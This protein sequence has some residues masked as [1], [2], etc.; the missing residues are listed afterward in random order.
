[1]G[2]T[3]LVA[4][5]ILVLFQGGFFTI[6]V[7][8]CGLVCLA[9]SFVAALQRR[10]GGLKGVV[11]PILFF[12]VAAAYAVSSVANGASL[13]TLSET[14]FWASA[15]AVSLLASLQTGEERGWVLGGLAW[16][17]AVTSLLGLAV[18]A[19]V[20]PLAAGLDAERLQFTFQ[21]ANAAGVWYAVCTM[22]CLLEPSRRLCAVAA[23]PATA[24]LL[25]ESGGATVAFCMVGLCVG[26]GL[27]KAEKWDL[28]LKALVS[29]AIAVISFG[30]I[31]FA[32]DP[33]LLAASV[34]PIAASAIAYVLLLHAEL[35]DER[36]R[37]LSLVA[38]AVAVCAVVLVAVLRW[39]RIVQASGTFVE[40]FIQMKDG[41]SLWSEN[42]LLGVGPDNWKHLYRYVQTAQYNSSVI[43]S[44]CVQILLDAGIAAAIPMVVA[45]L[46]GARRLW[47]RRKAVGWSAAE[48]ACIALITLHSFVDFD[49]KFG[50]LL[51]LLVFLVSSNGD[52]ALENGQAHGWLSLM[53]WLVCPVACAFIC[54]VGLLCEVST[55]ALNMAYTSGEYDR[56]K[57]LVEGNALA[58][59]DPEAL[60]WYLGSCVEQQEYE[61]AAQ[62]YGH[63]NNPTDNSTVY[64]AI[65][66]YMLGD[67][68]KAGGA[69]IGQMHL[70]PYN[71]PFYHNAQ[72]LTNTYGLDEPQVDAY[73]A[74]IDYA[75][76]LADQASESLP[77]QQ[78]FDRY[79]GPLMD[80]SGQEGVGA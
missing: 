73:N 42:M 69:I 30:L 56:C 7:C 38:L 28:L 51:F 71:V 1:M 6:P 23:L 62:M 8:I 43:H 66:Y 4:I 75:N 33:W 12:L 18:Y 40:R 77:E 26:V 41:I 2:V 11:M 78:H 39:G 37:K 25:T 14:G 9:V 55:T 15:V 35:S 63:M 80:Q 34:V 10:G 36:C 16:F 17:G 48:G 60:E 54:L 53:P 29:G 24:L 22:L 64:A 20:L 13:T 5:C 45:C 49:L 65:S 59:T 68:Q 52:D 72:Q 32:R 76:M 70:Q 67:V 27:V 57:E 74:A 19:G 46:E 3:L 79:T 47:R 31:R 58:H 44:S 61:Q 50:S 21:Y